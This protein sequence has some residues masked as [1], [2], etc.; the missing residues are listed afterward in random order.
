MKE[1]RIMLESK[2]SDDKLETVYKKLSE[3]LNY[4]EDK[5]FYKGYDK[6]HYE[7]YVKPYRE[8]N[9]EKINER[10]RIRYK[11]KKEIKEEIIQVS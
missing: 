5:K 11:K 6:D 4:K 7:N 8:K 1:L 10:E 2:L 9:R 3:V